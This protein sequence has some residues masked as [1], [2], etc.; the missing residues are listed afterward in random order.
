MEA[1]T[2]ETAD[3]NDVALRG[4]LAAAAEVRELPSG[5][6]V[7]TFRLIVGRDPRDGPTRADGKRGATVDTL[8]CSA[9]RSPARRQ[10]VRWQPGDVVEVEGS[11][12]RRFYRA[13]GAPV[14]RW[15]VL[16]RQAR[17]VARAPAE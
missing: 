10:V 3:R 12:R 13:A 17:R 6:A 11:L 16:V 1:G 8:D 14:S 7:A 2:V 9:W 4:R 15:D 5:D